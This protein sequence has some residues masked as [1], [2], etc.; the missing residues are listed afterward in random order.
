MPI[1]RRPKDGSPPPAAVDVDALILK[2]GSVAGQGAA[3]DREPARPPATMPAKDPTPVVL[4][5]PTTLLGRIDE[6][7]DARAVKIPRHTWL[8]EAVVEKL[9]R[10]SGGAG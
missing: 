9:E 4:R 8:L 6:A 7:L 2:G 3:S 1:S 10:E 5:V